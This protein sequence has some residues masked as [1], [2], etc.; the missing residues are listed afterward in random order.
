MPPEARYMWLEQVD[1]RLQLGAATIKAPLPLDAYVG[2]RWRPI[3]WGMPIPMSSGHAL[4][5]WARGVTVLQNWDIVFAFTQN[6]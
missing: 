5:L 6:T 2:N 4:L 3:T 1:N